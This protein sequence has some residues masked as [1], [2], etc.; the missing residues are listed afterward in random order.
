MSILKKTSQMLKRSMHL[1]VF[2]NIV[3]TATTFS[4][5]YFAGKKIQSYVLLIYAYAPQLQ[6]IE[7]VLSENASL[8]DLNKLDAAMAVINRAYDMIFMVSIISLIAFFLVF[9]LFQSLQ[10]RITFRSLK[11]AVKLEGIFDKHWGYA[12]KFS[13]ITI[14]AFL[15]IIPTF[16]S[17][18]DSI[19]ALFL[20][21]LIKMYDLAEVSVTVDY[22]SLAGLFILFLLLTYFAVLIYV[23]LN[24]EQKIVESVK[25]AFKTGV[26]KA[27][28]LLPIHFAAFIMILPIVYLDSLLSKLLNFKIAAIISILVYLVL[29]ACYQ[30]LMVA[31][32]EKK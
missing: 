21:L 7:A 4:L 16:Y 6:N 31:L 22:F 14:P 15:I 2:L 26:K 32:L 9:C 18:L 28:V 20:N 12:L 27:R 1:L 8:A 19:Q 24:K 23:I 30:V 29:A 10:W 5:L 11:K 3:F 25:K 13:L 17:F